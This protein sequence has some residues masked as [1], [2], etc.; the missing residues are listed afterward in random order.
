M[1][2]N[3]REFWEQKL[4]RNLERDAENTKRLETEGWLV[5]HLWEH[6]IEASP[7][8]CAQRIAVMLGK[9]EDTKA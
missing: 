7:E 3:N 6:E 9:T 4:R 5:L 8:R 1:P 2:K